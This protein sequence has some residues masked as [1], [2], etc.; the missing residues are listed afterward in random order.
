M[1]SFA[2]FLV[3]Y[4]HAIQY[5]LSSNYTDEIMWRIVYSFHMPLFMMLSGYF[6]YGAINR[7][8]LSSIAVKA[9]QLLLPLCTVCLLAS[10][11]QFFTTCKLQF[12]EYFLN[13]FRISLWFLKTAFSCFVLTKIVFMIIN[14]TFISKS[15][16]RKLL[17]LITSIIFTQIIPFFD[18]KIQSFTTGISTMYI[19]FIIGLIIRRHWDTLVKNN[20]VILLITG[21]I[22]ITMLFFLNQDMWE[23]SKFISAFMNGNIY[24]GFYLIFLRTYRILIGL[25]GSIFFIFLFYRLLK[26]NPK[27]KIVYYICD[28]G[29]YTLGIYIAQTYILETFLAKHVN[30]DNLNFM[31]FNFIVAPLISIAVFLLSVSLVKIAA[32]WR[33]TNCLLLGQSL[34]NK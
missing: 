10:T 34:K 18:A 21:T 12:F 15:R 9:R 11:I 19:A 31:M 32:K 4:G 3:I 22:F 17:I 14:L 33:V 30:F 6:A 2:I 23:Q 26:N 24:S 27:N 13:N 16:W 28:W 1:K 5:F 29:Q 25:S 7:P 20:K 8:F